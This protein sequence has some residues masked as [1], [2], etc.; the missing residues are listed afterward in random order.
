[1]LSK[2]SDSGKQK[3]TNTVVQTVANALWYF[4]TRDPLDILIHEI[5]DETANIGQNQFQLLFASIQYN[6]K[7]NELLL[8]VKLNFE[9]LGQAIVA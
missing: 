9:K 1:M 8:H 5:S 6:S 7:E 4:H 3:G 2:K